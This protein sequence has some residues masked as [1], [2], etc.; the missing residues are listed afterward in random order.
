MDGNSTD[1]DADDPTST[2]EFGGGFVM[3]V[4]LFVIDVR[5]SE[6]FISPK[7]STSIFLTDARIVSSILVVVVRF[8][9]A[10]ST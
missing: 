2:I 3:V 9:S 6:A 1:D 7:S 8:S 10:K 4:V 5:K